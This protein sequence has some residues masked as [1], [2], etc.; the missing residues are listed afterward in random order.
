MV[1]TLSESQAW[2]AHGST[3]TEERGCWATNGR[4]ARVTTAQRFGSFLHYC[5]AEFS[6][7]KLNACEHT[8]WKIPRGKM[9]LPEMICLL[10][11]C[12]GPLEGKVIGFLGGTG[13][14][15]VRTFRNSITS[16]RCG[17]VRLRSGSIR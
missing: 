13:G 15:R 8:Y 3:Q 14:K 4:E 11:L 5:G 1:I 2:K 12:I 16:F 10:A 17:G 7:H 9:E 6:S